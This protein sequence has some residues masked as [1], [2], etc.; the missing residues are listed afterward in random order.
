[1]KDWITTDQICDKEFKEIPD[2][3]DKRAVDDFLDII[4]D[5]IEHLQQYATYLENK[6]INPIDG[7]IATPPIPEVTVDE[8]MA[9][10]FETREIGY[11]QD[12]VHAFLDDICETIN[13]LKS[14]NARARRNVV[15]ALAVSIKEQDDDIEDHIE[16]YKEVIQENNEDEPEIA[17]DALNEEIMVKLNRNKFKIGKPIIIG[18]IA[19]VALIIVLIVIFINALPADRKTYASEA[20]MKAD[21]IGR[22]YNFYSTYDHSFISQIW[23]SDE[24]MYYIGSNGYESESVIEEWNYQ[25]GEISLGYS[26]YFT[27]KNGSIVDKYKDEYTRA[28]SIV[29]KESLEKEEAIKKEVEALKNET[30]ATA[31]KISEVKLTTEYNY[32]VCTGR[33]TNTGK[34]TYKYVQVKGSFQDE[35][36]KVLDTTWTYAVG[37]EG[38]SAGES[39]TFRMSVER[40]YNIKKVTVTLLDYD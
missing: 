40:D 31:L 4:C 38:L 23:F 36:G 14:E 32:K 33:V 37:S 21:V 28:Y 22:Y 19:A 3:Y 35:N 26:E 25:K 18:I 20:E 39:S 2:G 16:A 7:E 17:N 1:M 9:K 30:G 29:T 10:T 12:E 8:I 34:K 6:K 27:T 5:E 24:K 15:A 13:H 11:E